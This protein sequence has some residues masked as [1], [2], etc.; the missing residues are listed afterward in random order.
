[1]EKVR[2]LLD[3]KWVWSYLRSIFNPLVTKVNLP[4]HENKQK[5]PYVKVLLINERIFSYCTDT[6][7]E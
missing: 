7:R 4:I 2:D 5:V 6:V 3:S 1:M